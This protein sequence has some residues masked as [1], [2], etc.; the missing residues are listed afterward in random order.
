MLFNHS[1]SFLVLIRVEMTFRFI[2]NKDGVSL[3]DSNLNK[4]IVLNLE[5]FKKYLKDYDLPKDIIEKHYTRYSQAII[6]HYLIGVD[7]NVYHQD[8]WEQGEYVESLLPIIIADKDT[9][10][11]RTLDLIKE[12]IQQRQNFNSEYM[13]LGIKILSELNK[14]NLLQIIIN[15]GELRAFIGLLIYTVLIPDENIAIDY[16]KQTIQNNFNQEEINKI[17]NAIS[18]LL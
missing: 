9:E 3:F 2:H 17:I 12:Q 16:L 18:K 1:I 4:G 14:E 15:K 5:E 8:D 10:Q 7:N 13:P 11:N 6:Q